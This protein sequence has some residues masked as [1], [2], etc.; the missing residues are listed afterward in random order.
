MIRSFP[1]VTAI[2]L[3][4]VTAACAATG[5]PNPQHDGGAVAPNGVIT[6]PPRPKGISA[7]ALEVS[8][9][10]QA[11]DD[12][13]RYAR[14]VRA[15]IHID[16]KSPNAQAQGNVHGGYP[17]DIYTFLPY[18]HTIW[19][20]PGITIA[21]AMIVQAQPGLPQDWDLEC[22]VTEQGVQKDIWDAS[23]DPE[24]CI[25]DLVVG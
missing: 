9:H 6:Q 11:T 21:I 12:V 24:I 18:T 7:K 13:G 4:V 22:T 1:I 2:L 14:N 19:Y 8:L 16:A 5:R 15:N 3:L 17:F 20:E 23:I 10:V 25:I